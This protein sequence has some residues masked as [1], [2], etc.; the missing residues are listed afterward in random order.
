[1]NII[2][3]YKKHINSTPDGLEL[4]EFLTNFNLNSIYIKHYDEQIEKEQQLQYQM[5]S[6]FIP[7][8]FLQK[9]MN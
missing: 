2:D 6:L 4:N 8:F 1:M 7:Y 9:M 3:L 5:T